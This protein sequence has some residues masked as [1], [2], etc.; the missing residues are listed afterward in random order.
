MSSGEDVL[1]YDL[2]PEAETQNPAVRI[3][4]PLPM[5]PTAPDAFAPLVEVP[6]DSSGSASNYIQ[7]D[8]VEEVTK[9]IRL[10]F[11]W[12]GM[13]DDPVFQ[14]IGT[15]GAMIPVSD[16]RK[17]LNLLSDAPS[18]QAH[19]TTS[20]PYSP[21]EVAPSNRDGDDE[22]AGSASREASVKAEPLELT[23]VQDWDPVEADRNF[24]Q[25]EGE[26]TE[27]KLASLGVT[28]MPKP[29]VRTTLVSRPDRPMQQP[30]QMTDHY[31]KKDSSPR[32]QE[33]YLSLGAQFDFEPVVDSRKSS[34]DRQQGTS[35][36]GPSGYP[37]W[38]GHNDR[39]QSS[40]TI[41]SAAENAQARPRKGEAPNSGSS[42]APREKNF[43]SLVGRARPPPEESDSPS[44]E[45][46]RQQDDTGPR[47]KKRQPQVD[48]VYS[49][50]WL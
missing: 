50:R 8:N 49:R 30:S 4:R 16:Y 2:P 43:L 13:K 31:P 35:D 21:P 33:G 17:R 42:E 20:S 29:V 12:D 3:A 27:A 7:D 28:G 48:D 15:D 45:R 9:D 19:E 6:S 22:D 46:Q 18:L 38:R 24:E 5:D 11:H 44:T 25:P 23:N 47:R 14:E 10:S 1:D 34:F 40:A 26:D 41:P 37:A 39:R 36:G 32:S